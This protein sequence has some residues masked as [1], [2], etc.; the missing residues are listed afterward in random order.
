MDDFD[1]VG[2]TMQG[3]IDAALDDFGPAAVETVVAP[4]PAAL[5]DDEIPF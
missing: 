4:A 2:T 5:Q 1:E 3:G